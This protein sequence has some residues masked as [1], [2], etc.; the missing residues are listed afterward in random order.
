MI[1]K[2]R[3]EAD[4]AH[5]G[6][7][8]F[9]C[10]LIIPRCIMKHRILA[11]IITVVM[12]TACFP[13]VTVDRPVDGSAP[14][15]RVSAGTSAEAAKPKPKKVKITGSKYVA[16]G[17]KIT[18]KAT[19]TPD[20]ADQK[21]KWTS[22]N[23]KIATVSSKGV[24]KGKK[25]GKVK[26][27]A[28]SKSNPKAKKTFTVTVKADAVK[29]V[30]I[31]GA[32]ATLKIGGTAK[33]KA[34]ATPKKAAQSFEWTSSDKAVATVSSSGEVKALKKGKATITATATDGSKKK[35]T[36]VIEVVSGDEPK[37]NVES[38]VIN[39]VDPETPLDWKL[40]HSETFTAAVLP[41]N[42]TNKSVNWV[43]SDTGVLKTEA[44][45]TVTAVGCGTAAVH[46]EAKDGSGV[47]SEA[48]TVNVW[49][50]AIKDLPEYMEIGETAELKATARPD[51]APAVEW[52][53]DNDTAAEIVTE[54]G[55][56]QLK[57]LANGDVKVTATLTGLG[58][59][60]TKTVHVITKVTGITITDAPEEML[61]G[62]KTQLGV[63]VQPT[64]ASN[65]TVEWISSDTDVATV[66]DTGLV[67]AVGYGETDITAKAKDGSGV[68]ST[69]ETIKVWNVLQG[70][71]ITGLPGLVDISDTPELKFQISPDPSTLKEETSVTWTV[72]AGTGDAMIE[73]GKLK[74]TQTGTVTVKVAVSGTSIKAEKTVIIGKKVTTITLTAKEGEGEADPLDLL[75][76]ETIQ[77]VAAVEPADATNTDVIWSVSD[78]EVAVVDETGAVTALK[79]GTVT[80]TAT[81]ADGNGAAD[82]FALTVKSTV[83]SMEITGDTEL[84]L[85]MDHK[86]TTQLTATVLPDDAPQEITWES[87]DT[88]VATVDDNGL[89]TAVEA[90]TTIVT[91]TSVRVPHMAASIIITVRRST[92]LVQKNEDGTTGTLI[93]LV[94]PEDGA[95]LIRDT[96][97][98]ITI[99][100]LA[101]GLFKDNLALKSLSVPAGV[102]QIPE[103]LCEGCTN[104]EAALLPDGITLIGEKAFKECTKLKS[105]KKRE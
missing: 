44:D 95:A 87:S 78:E 76:N 99:T 80:I 43:S 81:A 1:P 50:I 45:G 65:Q 97:D 101:A 60:D 90:G 14:G 25:A 22:S 71:A 21:V 104:L 63:S 8:A 74:P 55:K 13:T 52:S 75:E 32:P 98:G 34:A 38:I 17:K 51:N 103:S 18:L 41:A 85:F 12:L 86:L 11:L 93:A 66:S 30:K 105:M 67:T 56:K 42:A 31:T 9:P 48:F 6:D 2:K 26:I 84:E 46:A 10:D 77:L 92:Y 5:E 102:T 29:S 40:E 96:Y 36:A 23:K 4:T 28:T 62:E 64:D 20:G 37:V 88:D 58:I 89:V 91:A 3:K 72:S 70:I 59:K 7:A 69:K 24:V 100:A 39:G 54:E 68:T 57:A 27:T 33:L 94:V 15:I 19:V 83:S 49:S 35:G 73:D 47:R 61:A 79:K 53:I 16:K 82:S